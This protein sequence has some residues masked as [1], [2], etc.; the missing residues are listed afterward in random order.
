MKNEMITE[1]TMHGVWGS[2]VI[3]LAVVVS[4]MVV[5]ISSVIVTKHGIRPIT[6]VVASC[7]TSSVHH[8]HRR[9]TVVASRI[10][11]TTTV[12]SMALHGHLVLTVV[13]THLGIGRVV[14]TTSSSSVAIPRGSLV[15]KKEC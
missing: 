12:R 4:V 11:T 14:S 10:A 3:G 1:T 8:G 13:V 6:V 7:A 15:L 2:I 5:A 9:G